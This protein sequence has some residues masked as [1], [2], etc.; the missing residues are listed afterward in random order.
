M[1]K[2]RLAAYALLYSATILWITQGKEKSPAPPSATASSPSRG[3][4]SIQSAPL[5]EQ[6][7]SITTRSGAPSPSSLPL[8]R[9]ELASVQTLASLMSRFEA[10][11]RSPALLMS[12]L[13]AAGL[14][15]TVAQDFNPD[16]GKMAIVRT[17]NALPGTRNVHVQLFAAEEA[18][19]THLQ[20]SS[21]EIRP[22]PDAMDAAKAALK[23]AFRNLGKPEIDE[24]NYAF[25]RI[26]GCRVA[27]AKRLVT[28]EEL[29]DNP[30]NA[31][32]PATDLGL[33]WVAIEDD[34]HCHE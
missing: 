17:K 2:F 8:R 12:A 33:V 32:D 10:I 4:A 26:P 3:I 24:P 19:D 20:H 5:N 29:A 27:W 15:P 23:A 25:W 30:F 22:A 6:S 13:K 28:E 1:T 18:G 7:D 9:E 16:T 34:P 14:E 31:H 21:W 11:E